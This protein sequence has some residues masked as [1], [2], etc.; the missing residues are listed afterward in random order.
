[1]ATRK[2]TAMG[3]L[4]DLSI[5]EKVE[6]DKNIN[7]FSRAIMFAYNRLTKGAKIDESKPVSSKNTYKPTVSQVEKIVQKNFS[8]NSRESKDAVEEARQIIASQNELIKKYADDLKDKIKVIDRKLSKNITE[9]YKNS[10]L[11]KREKRQKKLDFY[12]N[13]IKNKTVPPIHFGGKELSKKRRNNEINRED[14]LNQKYNRYCSRGDKTKGGNPHLRVIFDEN[15]D[16]KLRIPKYDKILPKKVK[17]GTMPTPRMDFFETPL[18]IA[19]KKSKKT[20]IVNGIN[21][22]KLVKQF[23]LTGEAYYVQIIKRNNKYYVHITINLEIPK[24]VAVSN[25]GVLGIDTNPDGLALTLISKKG[26]YK[27]HMYLKDSELMNARST[28]RNNLA[29]EIAKKAID[30]AIKYGVAIAIEDLEFKQNKDSNKR[31][32]RVRH[33][34]AYRKMLSSIES[35]CYKYGVELIKVNPS[36]T[37]K[38]GLYKYCEIYGIDIHNGA[39]LVIARRALGYREKIPK[40]LVNRFV[41]KDDREKFFVKNDNMRFAE[42]DSKYRAWRNKYNRNSFNKI[43]LS[44]KPNGY[45]YNKK[46]LF[47]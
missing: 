3:E 44:Y 34:F 35:R 31:F 12:Q 17:K 25:F 29:G 4:Y 27:T 21:Y 14:F 19:K 26:N 18:Y 11:S 6:L 39:A 8:L 40:K 10:L 37:S 16:L 43:K 38:I 46:K 20:G 9:D 41:R 47:L 15:S 30:I 2:I 32:N 7:E 5:D 33:N 1:M 45:L 23:I 42:I 22:E 36:Y 13:H 28:K 24:E